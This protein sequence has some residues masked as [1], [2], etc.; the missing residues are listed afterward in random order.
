VPSTLRSSLSTVGGI[1]QLSGFTFGEPPS[2]HTMNVPSP[3]HINRRTASGSTV[4]AR[5]T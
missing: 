5:P 1:I 2:A 3:L 4:V